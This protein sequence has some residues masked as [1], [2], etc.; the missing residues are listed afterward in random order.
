MQMTSLVS[1]LLAML[2]VA[3]LGAM[4]VTAQEEPV[5]LGSVTFTVGESG[6]N[7]GYSLGRHGSVDSGRW[8]AELV[9][10]DS[11]ALVTEVFEGSSGHWIFTGDAPWRSAEELEAF[12]VEAIYEDGRDTRSFVLGGFIEDQRLE[13]LK[14][15]PP[16]PPAASRDWDSKVGEVVTLLFSR[17]AI[18]PAAVAVAPLTEPTA[19]PGCFLDFLQTS[20]PGGGMIAQ[21]MITVVVFIGFT[22]RAKPSPHNLI[23]AS[24]VLIIT[25]WVPV[26]VFGIGSTILASIVAVNILTGA[27]AFKVFAARTEA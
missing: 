13:G 12:T 11:S 19:P 6:D 26:V 8:P 14:L 16:L 25:P 20:T 21:T 2:L 4:P 9:E 10:G 23:L 15:R 7:T 3:G 1:S 5:Q 17:A 24:I 22:L 27:F 18:P